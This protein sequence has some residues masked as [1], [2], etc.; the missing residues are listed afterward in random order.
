MYDKLFLDEDLYAFRQP[1]FGTT[2][3]E[4]PRT[5]YWHSYSYIMEAGHFC[6]LQTGTKSLAM[7]ILAWVLA[8][9]P[10]AKERMPA[11]NCVCCLLAGKLDEVRVC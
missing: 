6:A 1:V 8:K 7:H 5:L 2:Q 3:R 10:L 11:L 4:V 9:C